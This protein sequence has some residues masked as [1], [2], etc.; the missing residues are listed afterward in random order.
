MS[1]FWEF[2]GGDGRGEVLQALV[3]RQ[4]E[5]L[6]E[7]LP[8]DFEDPMQRLAAEFDGAADAV[9]T[10]NP[11]LARL[12]PPALEEA[13][14]AARFRRDALTTQ[15]RARLTAARTMLADLEGHDDV[16][17]VPLEHTNAWVMTMAGLRAQWNVEL[18][19][20]EERT[21]EAT[22]ADTMRNPTAAA[23]AD[24][25]GYLV[26]DLLEARAAHEEGF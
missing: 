7:L 2:D 10:A 9:V 16:V 20:S 14:D 24:W 18:T 21:A 5:P 23:V 15:V 1:G 11:V 25:L 17:L 4:V 22:F 12:F 26:E 3:L 8:D 19:G 13:E 6:A